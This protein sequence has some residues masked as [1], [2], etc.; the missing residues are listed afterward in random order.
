MTYREEH[1]RWYISVEFG[2]LFQVESVFPMLWVYLIEEALDLFLTFN[3]ILEVVK[4]TTILGEA[5][6]LYNSVCLMD[7]LMGLVKKYAYWNRH[8]G[9]H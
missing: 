3:S 8:M 1:F 4:T 9:K 2:K 5:A 6:F 7:M